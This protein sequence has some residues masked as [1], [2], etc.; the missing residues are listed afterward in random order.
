MWKH[1][2]WF[3]RYN[4][5]PSQIQVSGNESVSLKWKK[6]PFEQNNT[7]YHHWAIWIYLN[8][9]SKEDLPWLSSWF[10]LLRKFHLKYISPYS[11]LLIL[12]NSTSRKHEDL[13]VFY[14][15][16][17]RTCLMKLMKEIVIETEMGFQNIVSL[18]ELPKG[19]WHP[20]R[21]LPNNSL[22][23][24]SSCLMCRLSRNHSYKIWQRKSSWNLGKGRKKK[25]SACPSLS[26]PNSFFKKILSPGR[27]VG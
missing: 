8:K 19:H 14:S 18:Q 16:I 2:C 4:I 1:D 24:L 6:S 17:L 5:S 3:W 26:L 23:I 11:Q 25:F 13:H 12:S 20:K 15:Q 22:D 7:N 10:L 27:K 21:L 9:H